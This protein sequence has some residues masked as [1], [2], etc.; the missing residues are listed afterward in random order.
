MN[1][2]DNIPLVS[3]P[4]RINIPLYKHQLSSIYM[5][6][7]LEEEQIVYC[8]SGLI[9]HTK[10]GINSDCTGYGKTL[11][12]LGLI[13][14][15][16]MVWDLSIPHVLENIQTESAGLITNRKIE[17]YERINSNLVLVSS[18]LIHQ[19][20]NELKN[21]TLKYL[22]LASKKKIEEINFSLYDVVLVL[23]SIYNYLMQVNKNAWKRFIYDEPGHLRVTSMKKVIAGFYWLVTATPEQIIC[24][25][26]NCRE[27][28]MKKILVDDGITSI[29]EQFRGMIIKNN[30]EFVKA[31]F[32]MPQTFEFYHNCYQPILNTLCGVVNTTLRDLIE[33][34]NIQGAINHLGGAT[35]NLV[36]LV[37]QDK[38]NKLDKL[39]NS[40]NSEQN[41]KKLE[42]I[43][44]SISQINSEL[45]E[46]EQKS[47]EMLNGTC[48]ICMNVLESPVL[49]T[50]CQNIFCGKCFLQWLN[51][52][53]TCPLC[54]V[55]VT[56]ENIIYLS[57]S[58]QIK[59][60]KKPELKITQIEMVIKLV[61][62]NAEG[63]FIIY[64]CNDLSFE[65]LCRG[66]DENDVTYTYLK[67]NHKERERSLES[68]KYG[69]V[70][71]IF[72]NTN[73]NGSGINLQEATDIIMY[74]KMS[75]SIKQQIIGRANRIGRKK[76]L[77]VHYLKV[78]K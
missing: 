66:L 51:K 58:K 36:E 57:N 21:T 41:E 24:Q 32:N 31:S 7:N 14:R 69:N 42:K 33:S 60:D 53:S 61:N 16:R 5:M 18:S 46:I 10:I 35:K 54:R 8:S 68:F 52:S 29:Q 64:S 34:G 39:N 62:D 20:E 76:S 25:H 30:D 27:S 70:K 65:P 48:S 12:I 9:K 77:N 59:I 49:E 6:E 1:D 75:D 55:D 11:S 38:L 73:Y 72:L 2:F 15:D 74:H 43:Q 50:N 3:Q 26:K 17:R 13:A 23:P 47:L 45:E 22:I 71:V 67:G 44:E 37:K 78:N 28:F 40:R 4:S 63:K 56:K 19:W